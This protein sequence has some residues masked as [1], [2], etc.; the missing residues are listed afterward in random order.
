MHIQRGQRGRRFY[1][2]GLRLP[3]CSA[4][5]AHCQRPVPAP[6]THQAQPVTAAHTKP[7]AMP[8]FTQSRHLD[9]QPH[10]AII[11]TPMAAPRSATPRQGS[12][13]ARLLTSPMRPMTARPAPTTMESRSTPQ[14]THTSTSSSS[15][16]LTS[17]WCAPTSS[18]CTASGGPFQL[19][20]CRSRD[21]TRVRQ[22]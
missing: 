11:N 3:R 10:A 9:V 6:Y 15:N 1:S 4:S 20:D 18:R 13:T 12:P 8:S 19:H 5:W 2:Q 21:Y 14:R 17:S 16:S 7:A 22:P